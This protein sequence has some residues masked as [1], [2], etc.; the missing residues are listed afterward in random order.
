MQEA[1]LN[2]DENLLRILTLGQKRLISS[3]LWVHTLLESDLE[4]YRNDDLNSW[5]FL[6]F[7][8]ITELDPLFY[9][10]YLL[11]GNYLSVVKDDVWGA[12]EIYEKGLRR[13]PDDFWLRFHNGFNYYFE[14]SDLEMAIKNYEYAVENPIVNQVAP[15]LPSLLSRLKASTDGP[16]E[17]FDLL[18]PLYL[19]QPDDSAIKRHQERTLYSLRAEID[20]ECLNSHGENCHRIDFRGQPYLLIDGEYVTQDDW[21]KARPHQRGQGTRQ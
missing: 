21:K 11:G 12:R 20:L 18:F 17:A 16:A 3:L 9:E 6:R 13:F 10:A 2:F 8:S 1:T 19:R 5:M 15:Y 7:N 4:H 14:L